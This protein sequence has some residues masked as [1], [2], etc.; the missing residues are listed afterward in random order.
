MHIYINR[1]IS[2]HVI[3]H[4]CIPERESLFLSRFSQFSLEIETKYPWVTEDWKMIEKWILFNKVKVTPSHLL[5]YALFL[6]LLNKKNMNHTVTAKH[7]FWIIDSIFYILYYSW[8]SRHSINQNKRCWVYLFP[9]NPILCIS[10]HFPDK[11]V[12]FFCK[13]SIINKWSVSTWYSAD[14]T[15]VNCK[16]IS[17]F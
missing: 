10:F 8:Y 17:D 3:I 13:G 9:A 11:W 4:S 1:F 5:S 16:G 15:L 6:F 14:S 12:M 2:Q 7:M